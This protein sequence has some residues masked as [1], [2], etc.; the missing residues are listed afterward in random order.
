M[1]ISGQYTIDA[2]KNIVWECLNNPEILK[3]CIDGCTEFEELENH[4]FR[5]KVKSKIGPLSVIFKGN[6]NLSVIIPEKSYVIIGSGNGGMAGMVKAKVKV[7]LKEELGKTV[8]YYNA[9]G[10]ISGKL[11]QLGTR[12]IEGSV[13][14]YSEVFFLNFTN[15]LDDKKNKKTPDNRSNDKEFISKTKFPL[16]FW[17]WIPSI[18][19]IMILIVN[20]FIIY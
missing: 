1:N 2:K 5:T 15:I 9:D 18:I 6:F 12:L 16:P 19:F 8:L 4:Q 14:K 3:Q 10:Q 20:Y 11:A 7:S 13:K 17:F